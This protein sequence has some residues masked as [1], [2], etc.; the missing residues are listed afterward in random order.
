M[1]TYAQNSIMPTTYWAFFPSSPLWL[2]II[3]LKLGSSWLCPLVF[4]DSWLLLTWALPHCVLETSFF[5]FFFMCPTFLILALISWG[6]LSLLLI[7]AL[8]VVGIWEALENDVS[9]TQ[10]VRLVA[11]TFLVRCLIQPICIQ[12][13]DI[14]I[15]PSS[16]DQGRFIHRR[17]TEKHRLVNEPPLPAPGNAL[18]DY[19]IY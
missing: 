18:W 15:D 19:N 5:L 9:E 17:A 13:S 12:L 1:K 2:L 6:P 8:D 10:A 7:P 16:I 11:S 3:G 4:M 14:C